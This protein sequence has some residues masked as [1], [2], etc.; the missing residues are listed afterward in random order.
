M[1]LWRERE[2]HFV[3]FCKS[4]NLFLLFSERHFVFGFLKFFCELVFRFLHPLRY[5]ILG[6]LHF[7]RDPLFGLLHLLL[8]V[9]LHGWR[10]G[11]VPVLPQ[12]LDGQ[13]RSSESHRVARRCGDLVHGVSGE[14]VAALR[15]L[16]EFHHLV[17]KPNIL[18]KWHQIDSFHCSVVKSAEPHCGG[19]QVHRDHD[20]AVLLKGFLEPLNEADGFVLQRVRILLPWMISAAVPLRGR[21]AEPARAG[22]QACPAAAGRRSQHLCGT[23]A[24][25]TADLQQDSSTH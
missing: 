13:R 7:P 1:T 14:C 5:T 23:A 11:H 24:G 10:G 20:F 16:Q 9:F 4:I 19:Q 2:S 6:L 25:R 3:T 22:A 8:Q 12:V 17:R 15:I 18:K 21:R